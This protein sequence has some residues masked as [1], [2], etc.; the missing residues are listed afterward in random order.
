MSAFTDMLDRDLSEAYA[1]ILGVSSIGPC[2]CTNG[3]CIEFDADGKHCTVQ[4]E[5]SALEASRSWF[6]GFD[7]VCQSVRHEW[8]YICIGEPPTD[9][10]EM[11]KHLECEGFWIN[12][13]V[14]NYVRTRAVLVALRDAVRFSIPKDRVM[15][16]LQDLLC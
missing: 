4:I 2:D 7:C 9:R 5:A 3:R 8:P 11:I 14:P 16:H 15:S 1:A 6:D 13:A 10:N 12:P